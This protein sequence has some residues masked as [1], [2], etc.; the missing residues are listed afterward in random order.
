MGVFLPTNIVQLRDITGVGVGNTATINCPKGNRY[1]RIILLLQDTGSGSTAAPAVS[2][3]TSGDVQVVLG[4]KT[5][6]Q[7]HGHAN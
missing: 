7:S 4:S 2:A 3:V 6:S 1:R 5:H